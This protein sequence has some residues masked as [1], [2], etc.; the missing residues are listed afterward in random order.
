MVIGC[1]VARPLRDGDSLS[2][3]RRAE[4]GGEGQGGEGQGGEGQGGEEQG[5]SGE[6]A[7]I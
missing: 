2:Q 4:G 7:G 6:D 5:Q 1:S 3:P